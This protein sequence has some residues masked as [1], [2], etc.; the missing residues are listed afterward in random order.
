MKKDQ[1]RVYVKEHDQ[2][3]EEAT[4]DNTLEAL[5]RLVGGY[6]ETVYVDGR[7]V[8]I[9]NEEGRLCRL[10]FNLPFQEHDLYGTVVAVGVD[11]EEFTDV[12]YSDLKSWNHYFWGLAGE[13]AGLV[14]VT[15]EMLTSAPAYRDVTC[16][17][18]MYEKL[19]ETLSDA[20]EAAGGFVFTEAE[21]PFDEKQ[22]CLYLR[23]DYENRDVSHGTIKRRVIPHVQIAQM[24]P[25]DKLDTL[26]VMKKG[27]KK[28]AIKTM[29]E[30]GGIYWEKTSTSMDGDIRIR[31]QSRIAVRHGR[32]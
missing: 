29:H 15:V 4:I 1:I 9:V 5:Q 13:P 32:D 2:Q 14:K 16:R 11:G 6:I 23:V 19:L 20:I 28:S 22:R 27:M 25:A 24:Y 12:P 26:D 3:W 18:Q 10:P 17:E 31:A 8:L 21:A 7:V 30:N